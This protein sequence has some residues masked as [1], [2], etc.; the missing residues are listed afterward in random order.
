MNAPG[1]NSSP[2]TA[3]AEHGVGARVIAAIA[4]PA[5]EGALG[6]VRLSGPDVPA[7]AARFLRAPLSP[8]QACLGL[9]HDEGEPIERAMSVFFPGPESYTGENLL[10]LTAHGSPYLLSRILEL[11]VRAGARLAEPGEFTRRAYLNGRMDLAQAEA[12]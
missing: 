2:G 3:P 6:I 1:S 7:I 12:V 9:I 11:A 10:E 5:G 4:T 8:R